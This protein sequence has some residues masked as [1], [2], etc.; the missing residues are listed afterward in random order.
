MHGWSIADLVADLDDDDDE[1]N[2][3]LPS[4]AKPTFGSTSS[5]TELSHSTPTYTSHRA[6]SSSDN[7]PRPSFS[8]PARPHLP[9]G[10][11]SYSVGIPTP[12]YHGDEP[13]LGKFSNGSSTSLATNGTSIGSTPAFLQSR[14]GSKA[15]LTSIRNAFKASAPTP[16]VPNVNSGPYPA[17]K[18]PF[19]RY[20]EP[21]SPSRPFASPRGPHIPRKS[22]ASA[23]SVGGRS[24]TSQSSRPDDVPALPPIPSRSTPSRVGRHGSS[25]G[26]MFNFRRHGSVGALDGIDEGSVRT[27]GE[28]ALR[29]VWREFKDA[30]DSKIARICGR[31]LVSALS[32]RSSS[33][34]TH[35]SLPAYLDSAIDATFDTLITSLANCGRRHARKVADLLNGWCR[36]HCEGIGASEVRAHLDR[37]LGLQMRVEDAAAILGG[38]K[39]SA[40]RFILN[41]ALI[42]VVRLTPKENLGDELGMLLEQNAFNAYRAEKLE[43]TMQVP[44]RKAVSQLQIELLGQLSTSRWVLTALHG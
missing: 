29:V 43:E 27:A 2:L 6:N 23:R 15:S 20:N 37:S 32:G 14:K 36:T 5:L 4:F 25:D 3:P 42:E 41:R 11:A 33:Q 1:V 16:P 9:H 39:S 13:R 28:E 26:S 10:S 40:A 30:A 31:P 44:H 35:P 12:P 21:L 18:N 19:S 38:R 17:L 7:L 22:T 24:A 34:N 8:T